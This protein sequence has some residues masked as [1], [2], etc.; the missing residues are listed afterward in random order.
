VADLARAAAEVRKRPRGTL[1]VTGDADAQV[2][3][4]GATATPVAG[5]VTFRDLTSGEH[6]LAVEELGRARWG[7]HVAI[8]AATVEQVIPPRPALGLDDAVAAAH[9]RRM[10]ARFALVGE[11]NGPG[12]RVELRFRRPGGK[13][14]ATAR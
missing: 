4:D 6:L 5:G 1:I 7:T 8:A 11:R 12:A 2:S 3:L 13:K 10:G 9:A 14:R